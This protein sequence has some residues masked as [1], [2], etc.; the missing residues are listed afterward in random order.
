VR[1][2]DKK[3]TSSE[4]RIEDE[5]SFTDGSAIRHDESK[6]NIGRGRSKI[7]TVSGLVLVLRVVFTFCGTADFNSKVKFFENVMKFMI[8]FPVFEDKVL[9]LGICKRNSSFE[10]KSSKQ[11]YDSE[12]FF[13]TT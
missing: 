10:W 2:R 6:V 1:R 11:F 5:F 8:V 9:I 12:L 4:E 3:S 7:C 13:T